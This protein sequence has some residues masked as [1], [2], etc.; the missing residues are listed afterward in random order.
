[1]FNTIINLKPYKRKIKED[2]FGLGNIVS[3]GDTTDIKDK[4]TV[5]KNFENNQRIN[6]SMAVESVTK[7]SKLTCSIKGLF[8]INNFLH[9]FSLIIS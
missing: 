3:G 6:R 5:N 8:V 4:T 2:F 7:L 9:Y 1:M